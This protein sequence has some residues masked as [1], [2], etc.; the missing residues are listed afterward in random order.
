MNIE[1]FGSRESSRYPALATWKPL[2]SRISSMYVTGLGKVRWPTVC[3]FD[4]THSEVFRHLLRASW[5]YLRSADEHLRHALKVWKAFFG[6]GWWD[7][8]EIHYVRV[9]LLCSTYK[10]PDW[11]HISTVEFMW[12]WSGASRKCLCIRERFTTLYA[13]NVRDRE[14]FLLSEQR[15]YYSHWCKLYQGSLQLDDVHLGFFSIL[16]HLLQ[17]FNSR[18]SKC[19]R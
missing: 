19:V 11:L 12:I 15:K 8:H 13:E 16:C 9:S 18:R 1:A 7:I 3:L 10:R 5:V 2:S 14:K 4:C 17:F 6:T